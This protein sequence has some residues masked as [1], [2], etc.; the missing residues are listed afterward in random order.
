MKLLAVTLGATALPVVE[1]A[2]AAES[3]PSARRGQYRVPGWVEGLGEEPKDSV[4]GTGNRKVTT[5]RVLPLPTGAQAPAPLP[6]LTFPSA[7]VPVAAAPV[8]IAATPA[9]DSAGQPGRALLRSR[10]TTDVD[11]RARLVS[12]WGELG[13]EAPLARHAAEFQEE[14][15][16]TSPTPR[17]ELGP[18]ASVLRVSDDSSSPTEPEAVEEGTVALARAGEAT[19]LPPPEELTQ[20]RSGVASVEEMAPSPDDTPQ[21][22]PIDG[23]GEPTLAV[24]PASFNG[25]SPGRSTVAEMKAAMQTKYGL[26]EA[27][28]REDGSEGFAWALDNGPFERA[29]A[30]CAG[31][32]VESIRIKLGDPLSVD[33]LSAMWEIGDLNS[34][35]I[36]DES[37]V[38]IGEVFP[39]LGLI[40]SLK[41]GTRSALAVMIEPLDPEA[42][43]LRAEGELE[44]DTQLALLDLKYAVEID[45]QHLR[46]RRMLMSL[47]CEQGKWQQALAI[48]LATEELDPEDVWTR[49]KNASVLMSLGRSDEARSRVEA[50][51]GMRGLEAVASAQVERMI[52]RIDIDGTRPDHKSAVKHFDAAIRTAMPLKNHKSE[53]IRN[54]AR[55]V[56]LDANLGMAVA[57]AKG[58]WQK[59]GE[60]AAKWLA[61]ATKIVD[62]VNP[63]AAER[64]LLDIQLCRGALA[65]ASGCDAIAPLPWVKRLLV[66]RD[67]MADDLGDPWRRRQIDWEVG[68]GLA[69]ALAASQKRGESMQMLDNA[70]LTVAYLERG[71][72]QRE[73][74]DAERATIGDLLFRI[75]VLHSIQN[76]DHATAVTW[77]D[78]VQPYWSRNACFTTHGEVGRLGESYVSMAV[79]YWQV[80]RRDD[81]LDLCR[82]GID[83]MVTAVDARQLEEPSLALAY[84]NISMMYAEQGEE[85]RSRTYAE[86]ASRAEAAGQRK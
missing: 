5:P 32:V 21:L 74:T 7:P 8:T 51:K 84:G 55:D 71:A 44:S 67:Q 33:E 63:D 59:K 53:S 19:P 20:A 46:A 72:E 16:A 76:G 85:E 57:I 75:G 27:F 82:R 36:L 6:P 66:T 60:V 26:G 1:P 11:S 70:T 30:T 73:L 39:E 45:P 68:H 17:H 54:A 56:L 61:A 69:D 64:P 4:T 41:P 83:C 62:D 52:G 43:V 86:M 79:S 9:T 13:E 28:S 10:A 23:D 31:D 48:G 47:L 3:A 22:A 81:A 24:D 2:W 29:E 42:F 34:V 15:P 65:A 50:V 37:G 14:T 77:F 80:D 58:D 18:E 49:L 40:F 38:S 78:K 35:S 25:I 12:G